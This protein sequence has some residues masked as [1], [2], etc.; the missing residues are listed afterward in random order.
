[1]NAARVAG[2]SIGALSRATGIPIETL[3]TW[4]SRY[5]FPEP[6]RRPS[7]HRTYPPA[8]VVRLK[9]IAEALARGFRAG[10]VV[11]ASD[12][13]LGAMLAMV[14]EPPDS[15]AGP[16]RIEAPPELAAAVAAV[17][18]FDHAGLRQALIDAWN[19]LGATTFFEEFA[20]PLLQVV[21]EAWADGRLEIR[22]EHFLTQTF[23]DVV[24]GLRR[25]FDQRASGPRVVFATLPGERH[26]LGL[27]MAALVVAMA[28]G[29]VIYLG[30][31]TPVADIVRLAVDGA[32]RG[33]AVSMSLAT[34]GVRS[35][36]HLA[37]LRAHLPQSIRLACGGN[38]A[39]S[40]VQGV[41]TIRHL[42]ELSAWTRALVEH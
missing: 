19:R 34:R 14:P 37:A 1:M 5:G 25:D 16:P 17:T 6:E 7:G 13:E 11:G 31:D 28:G 38:G 20:A 35:R 33:V 30:P 21:G 39:P 42:A 29:R 12:D 36:R 10:E 15:M 23:G 32:A 22:H 40:P 27:Q 3:R 9:R 8:T 2:L 24:R 41:A 18:V 4:E 26:E